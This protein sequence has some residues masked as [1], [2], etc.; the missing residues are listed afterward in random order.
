MTLT[1]HEKA[2]SASI[3][4]GDPRAAENNIDKWLNS[5]LAFSGEA[6]K[7]PY[8]YGSDAGLCARKNVL[9][10]HNEWFP[11]VKSSAT[12][13]YMAIGVGL[14]DMLAHAL[15][16][17]GLLFAQGMR[18][19][20]MPQLKI[21]G[22]IDLIIID[23]EEELALIEVKTCGDLPLEPKVTHLAQIQIYAAVSGIH[24]CYLTYISRN[25]R[26]S[27]QSTVDMRT[28]VVD[29]SEEVLTDRL[30]TA[31]LSRFA[32]DL[33]KLPP[34]P[35]HFRK[36]TECHYCPFM[37]ICWAPRPG[38]GGGDVTIELPIPKL[39]VEELAVLYDKSLEQA[40][41]LYEYSDVRKLDTIAAIFHLSE[42]WESKVDL[43][44]NQ[45]EFLK[46]E[47]SKI[48]EEMGKKRKEPTVLKLP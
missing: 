47:R 1:R 20:D 32:S 27:F 31:S 44:P 22:K 40:K 48:I 14:E 7:R 19:V 35:A 24:K 23:H 41:Y 33:G 36:H 37:D 42:S 43:T 8:L 6:I 45:I 34:V 26:S 4:V 18:L 25:V 39:G 30:K 29:T 38:R 9:L 21:S 2:G 12:A 11:D 16:R 13:A 17:R 10:E 5:V 46:K 3:F 28:F 15:K